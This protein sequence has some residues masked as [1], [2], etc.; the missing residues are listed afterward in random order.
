VGSHGHLVAARL[1]RANRYEGSLDVDVGC[2]LFELA[3]NRRAARHSDSKPLAAEFEELNV[4]VAREPHEIA[5]VQ[6]NLSSRTPRDLKRV[7]FD[8]WHVHLRR[9]PIPGITASR[10]DVAVDHAHSSNT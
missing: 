8:D 9:D 7:S 5:V 1:H 4:G 2:A 10:H 3:V 6:L